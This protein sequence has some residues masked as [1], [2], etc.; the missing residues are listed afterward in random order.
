MTQP[1]S[2][3]AKL[4]FLGLDNTDKMSSHLKRQFGWLPNHATRRHKAKRK[5]KRK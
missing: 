4:F 2:T 1:K 3:P 5:K